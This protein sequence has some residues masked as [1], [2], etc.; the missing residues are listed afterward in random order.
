MGIGDWGL[1]IGD[2][3]LPNPQSPIPNPHLIHV[4]SKFILNIFIIKYKS[5]FYNLKKHKLLNNIINNTRYYK[6]ISKQPIFHF[7]FFVSY[8][9]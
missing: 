6:N 3:G 8:P 1:G 5:E 7:K 9:P 2:W 4:K